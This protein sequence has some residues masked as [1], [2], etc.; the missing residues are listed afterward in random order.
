VVL[1]VLLV[2]LSVVDIETFTLPD[3][4]IATLAAIG[5]LVSYMQGSET[6]AWNTL[7]AVAVGLLVFG[8]NALYLAIRGQHGIGMG[9]AKLLAAGA[10]WVGGL[11]ILSVILWASLTG[12]A[13]CLAQ[14]I[15]GRRLQVRMKIPFGPHIALGIWIVWLFGP[16]Q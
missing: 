6:L 5:L 3:P 12:L 14:A 16:I 10:L 9:D 4:L 1:A 15:L 8:G 2:T 11:G 13:H 7:S